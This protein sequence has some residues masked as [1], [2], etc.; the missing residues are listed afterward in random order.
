LE[1]DGV[2][3]YRLLKERY[4]EGYKFKATVNDCQK[5]SEVILG[6]TNEDRTNSIEE[7]KI[8]LCAF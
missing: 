6:E 7:R 8:F 1:D 2:W 3:F 5:N 4:N